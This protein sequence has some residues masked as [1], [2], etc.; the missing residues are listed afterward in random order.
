MRV[1]TALCFCEEVGERK[2]EANPLTVLLA[3]P[4]WVGALRWMEMV[5]PVAANTRQ[6]LAS[7]SFIRGTETCVQSPFEFVHGSPIW[8]VMEDSS[9]QRHN[10]DMWMRERKKH[11]ETS[12][13][14][15]YP[16]SASFD[17]ASMKSSPDAVLMIDI[18]GATG[19]QLI[20]FHSQFPH[21][22][23][24]LILQDLPVAVASVE[25]P[26]GIEVQAYDFFTPQPMKGTSAAD[27][28]ATMMTDSLQR[29]QV[30]LSPQC[31][32]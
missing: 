9:D 3:Q 24:R 4:G 28:P 20:N 29:C 26:D 15:I 8:K 10:F 6:F 17:A 22:P 11:Q 31:A 27:I 30:L 18:G 5:Y 12:W 16:P 32:S 7:K 14:R 25:V 13:H 2:Y 19:S 23:G 21:L 1:L